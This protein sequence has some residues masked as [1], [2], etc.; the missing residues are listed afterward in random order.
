[1]YDE[2]LRD[3]YALPSLSEEVRYHWVQFIRLFIVNEHR[4]E[5]WELILAKSREGA[6]RLFV[7]KR[8]FDLA[9]MF[10]QCLSDA[11]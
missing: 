2:P 6:Q 8:E 1:V 9:D 4:A 3:Q 10:L 7:E 11:L 5:N